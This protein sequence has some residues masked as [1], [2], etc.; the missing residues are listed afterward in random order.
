M[1]WRLT[2][3][4]IRNTQQVFLLPPSL[5]LNHHRPNKKFRIR[6]PQPQV[7]SAILSTRQSAILQSELRRLPLLIP[8][9][10]NPLLGSAVGTV[11]SSLAGRP[12]EF[13]AKFT[14]RGIKV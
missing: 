3:Q 1:D 5:P 7:R 9:Q 8:S 11:E 13:H 12:I 2:A 14:W 10:M 4:P 6:H